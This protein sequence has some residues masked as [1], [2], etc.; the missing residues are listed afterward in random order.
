L[1]LRA[2]NETDWHEDVLGSII[3]PRVIGETDDT[4]LLFGAVNVVTFRT[5]QQSYG[6]RPIGSEWD[7]ETF[8]IRR[9]IR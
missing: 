6:E 8:G 2:T 7:R 4:T 1:T 5:R 9:R 3:A